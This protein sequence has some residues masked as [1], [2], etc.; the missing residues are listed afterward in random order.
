LLE[1]FGGGEERTRP[2]TDLTITEGTG[3]AR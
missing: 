1:K 3:G 2:V